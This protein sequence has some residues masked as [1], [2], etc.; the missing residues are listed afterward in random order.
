MGTRAVR[1]VGGGRHD[2]RNRRGRSIRV[3]GTLAADGYHAG[4]PGRVVSVGGGEPRHR[5]LLIVPGGDEHRASG[6]L[7]DRGHADGDSTTWDFID[8]REA[9][10]SDHVVPAGALWELDDA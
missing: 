10:K 7:G 3:D 4:R 9:G 8:S 6:Q 2:R 5:L 1:R